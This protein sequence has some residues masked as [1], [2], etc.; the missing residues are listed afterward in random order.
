[1]F[2][3]IPT[4]FCQ[5]KFTIRLHHSHVGNVVIVNSRKTIIISSNVVLLAKPAT[6]HYHSGDSKFLVL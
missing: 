5:P 4:L 2:K 6:M 1:L 3:F